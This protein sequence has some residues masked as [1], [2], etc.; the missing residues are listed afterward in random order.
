M[1]ATGRVVTAGPGG[2][3]SWGDITGK[4]A[5]FPPSTHSHA[6]ADVT[7]KPATFPPSTHSHAYADVTGKPATFPPSA[8][9]HAVSDVT[10]LTTALEEPARVYVHNGTTYV[11]S[12]TTDIFIGPTDPGSGLWIDTDA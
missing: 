12:T 5:T 1:V 10:G 4:P 8:H 3:S 6:Y 2:S 7:D 9:S 11:L